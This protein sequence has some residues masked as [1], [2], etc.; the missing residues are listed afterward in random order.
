M[1][2]LTAP[3]S[4]FSPLVLSHF[5]YVRDGSTL[6]DYILSSIRTQEVLKKVKLHRSVRSLELMRSMR[7]ERRGA[8]K[9]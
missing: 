4:A 6:G 7:P 9:I 1:W 8:H 3:G 5:L 2:I